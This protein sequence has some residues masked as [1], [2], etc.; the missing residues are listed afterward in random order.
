MRGS[1]DMA[2]DTFGVLGRELGRWEVSGLPVSDIRNEGGSTDGL[3]SV[4]VGRH[5]VNEV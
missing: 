2:V 3:G 1:R 4:G 5:G